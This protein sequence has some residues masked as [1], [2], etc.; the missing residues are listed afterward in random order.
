[1]AV[2]NSLWGQRGAPTQ[3]GFL[4]H[5]TRHYGGDL[6]LVDFR[7]DADNVRATINQWVEGKTKQRIRDLIPAALR[8]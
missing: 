3:A 4:D 7:L 2:A 8:R 6:N 5:F 1:M